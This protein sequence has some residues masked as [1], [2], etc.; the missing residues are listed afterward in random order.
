[1]TALPKLAELLGVSVDAL[2]QG[3][4]VPQEAPPEPRAGAPLPLIFQAVAVAMGV[5]VAVLATLKKIDLYSGFSMLGIGL[6]CAGLSLLQAPHR[7]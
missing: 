6:A 7:R 4:A 5:A 1:M 2:L 3:A